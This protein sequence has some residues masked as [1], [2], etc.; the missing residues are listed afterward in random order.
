MLSLLKKIVPILLIAIV[1]ESKIFIGQITGEEVEAKEL[2]IINSIFVDVWTENC[3]FKKIKSVP[4]GDYTEFCTTLQM[5]QDDKF[6]TGDIIIIAENK[7]L[8]LDV[9]NYQGIR[10]HVSRLKLEDPE[11]YTD[12]FIEARSAYYSP[13]ASESVI[14]SSGKHQLGWAISIGSGLKPEG[15]E[16]VVKTPAG[17]DSVL[18]PT[19]LALTDIMITD[20]IGVNRD[21]M[22]SAYLHYNWR[23]AIG[24]GMG[25]K[26][27]FFKRH[28]F[29]PSVGFDVGLN[30]QIIQTVMG[31]DVT[32]YVGSRDG[33]MVQAKA[34]MVFLRDLKRN[35][36]FDVAYT[37]ILS[38]KRASYP[39]LQ[40]GLISSTWNRKKK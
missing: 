24:I 2:K 25:F 9:Y 31:E 26:K 4:N 28:S 35:V 34:G 20:L 29:S 18:S 23:A 40:F 16:Y 14:T 8:R 39:S 37:A 6:I 27:M 36:Y 3:A 11:S 33:L 19:N 15:F 13:T 10:E 22:L 32:N 38:E 17:L 21:M 5:L 30:K 7:Y 1:A 12:Q